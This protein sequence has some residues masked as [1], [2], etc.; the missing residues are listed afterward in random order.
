[1]DR[2]YG[3]ANCRLNGSKCEIYILTPSFRTKLWN[4]NLQPVETQV[5]EKSEAIDS[6][7]MKWAKKTKTRHGHS[8]GKSLWIYF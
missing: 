1:M 3:N 7:P 4:E 5:K 8:Q 6:R 2:V